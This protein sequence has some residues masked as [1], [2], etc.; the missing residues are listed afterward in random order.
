L[1]WH[2][3]KNQDKKDMADKKT[4]DINRAYEVLSD[5]QKKDR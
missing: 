5:K 3:D 1:R 4:K 2:P